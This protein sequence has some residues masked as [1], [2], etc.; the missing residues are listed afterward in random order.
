[1]ASHSHPTL[2]VL[3]MVK[4]CLKVLEITARLHL[5]NQ[6]NATT[7]PIDGDYYFVNV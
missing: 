6:I 2:N 7:I 4:H 5:L 3:N 1:M